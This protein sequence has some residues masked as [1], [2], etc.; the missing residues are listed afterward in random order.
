MLATKARCKDRW[1]QILNEADRIERKHLLT[2]RQGVSES[3]F[4]Y[5]WHGN[6]L[7]KYS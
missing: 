2:L 5:E 7:C 1:C 4:G 3:Q 6:I